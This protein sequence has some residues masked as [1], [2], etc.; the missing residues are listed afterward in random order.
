LTKSPIDQL[1]EAIDTLDVEAAIALMAPNCQMLAVDG[2]RAEGAAAVR[3]LLSD[4]LARILQT[5]HQISA[6]WHQDDVWIAEVDATY[7]LEDRV[8]IRRPRAFVLRDG[9]DGFVELHVYGAHDRPFPDHRSGEEGMRV[10]G[11]WIPP[12]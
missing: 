4:F 7:E 3:E 12:L 2:R 9:P 6:Q 10:G 11:R 5:T 8:R 1:L